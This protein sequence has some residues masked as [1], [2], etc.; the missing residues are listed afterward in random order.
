[1]E[2]DENNE[3]NLK[4][5]SMVNGDNVLIDYIETKGD[6]VI[7]KYPMSMVIDAQQGGLGM[8]PYLA[9]FTGKIEKEFSLSTNFIIKITDDLLEDIKTNYSNYL[10]QLQEEER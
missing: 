4:L 9:V 5:I 6:T 7:G 1:M 2:N 8:V 3:V 10:K